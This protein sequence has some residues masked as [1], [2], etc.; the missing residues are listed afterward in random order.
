[1]RGAKRPGSR[2]TAASSVAMSG[3][4]SGIATTSAGSGVSSRSAPTDRIAA[5]NRA[6]R[7]SSKSL[8]KSPRSTPSAL[9]NASSLVAPSRYACSMATM[10]GN[11][12]RSS[13]TSKTSDAW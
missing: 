10:A 1:M 11:P 9:S 7:K 8:S 3:M 6:F 2:A 5:A 12:C 13:I 4:R